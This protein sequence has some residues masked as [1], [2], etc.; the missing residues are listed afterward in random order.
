MESDAGLKQRYSK[1]APL[2]MEEQKKLCLLAWVFF[3]PL[4]NAAMRAELGLSETPGM[5]TPMSGND[6]L[7]WVEKNHD[8]EIQRRREA[9]RDLLRRMEA[10]GLLSTP[11]RK[12]V[13]RPA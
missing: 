11:P 6:L 1:L 10:A 12:L 5:L 4:K 7:R 9:V 2:T 8:P 3:S 13:T